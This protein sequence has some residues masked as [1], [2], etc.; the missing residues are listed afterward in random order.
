MAE[1]NAGDRVKYRHMTMPAEVISGPHRYPAGS[2]WLIEKSDGN[3]TL[4]PERDI[5]RIVPRLDQVA[6]TL[7][8]HVYGATYD[9]LTYDRRVTIARAASQV[10]HIADTTR[11]QA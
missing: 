8:V 4:V 5:E 2:R 3:V 10:L 9:A 6:D 11:G 1:F 7:A